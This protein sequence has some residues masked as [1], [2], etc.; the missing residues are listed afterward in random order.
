MLEVR[1][2]GTFEV[3][4]KNKLIDIPSRPAQSLFAY[5]ILNAGTSHRREKLAGLLW[6]DSMEETARD[7]LRHALWR[8][9]KALQSASAASYLQANDL[10][11]AFNASMEYW[12]DVVELAKLGENASAD[13]LITVLS[14]YHGELLPGFYDE[15]VGL[16]REHLHSIFEHHM[17]R[18]MSLLQEERRWLDILDW[19]ERWIK[20]GQKPE[21]AYRALMTVHAAK[22]D[23]SKVAATYQRCVKSLKELGVEPSEQ[24]H[25][26]Y[27]NLKASKENLET[28]SNISLREERTAPPKTNLPVPLTSFIGRE[29]EIEELKHLLSTTRLLTLTGAGGIGKTRLA[30]QLANDLVTAY[31]DGVW[32]V[33]LAPV[34][35]GRFVVQAVA[36]VLGVQESRVHSLTDS[37]NRFLREKQ[38]LI[39]LDNCE[40]VIESSA[41]LA[42]DLLSHCAHLQILT[43]S[44]ESLAITGETT[45]RVPVLTF[46]VL[47]HLPRLQNLSEFE[48]I[49]LFVERAVAVHPE[50]ALTPEN[51]FAVTQICHRLDG[52]PLA[53]ELAAARIKVFS[54]EEIA[55]RL[56]DRFSLLTHGSRTAL[57]RHQT[58][59]ALVEWSYD[60]LPESERILWRR[61]SVFIGGWTLEAA[62]SICSDAVLQKSHILELLSHLV[63]KSLVIVDPQNGSTRYQMLETIRQ[64]GQEI[65]ESSG[66]HSAI[67]RKHLVYFLELAETAE[68]NLLTIQQKMWFAKL[69]LEYGNMRAA[70]EWAMDAD[71]TN[72]LRLAA[73]LSQYWEVRGF[74]SEGRTA[75]ERALQPTPDVP[76]ELRAEGLRW[77]AK[78]AARQGDYARAKEPLK[79]SLELSRALGDKLGMAKSLHNLGMVFSLQGDYGA[80]KNS[81]ETGLALLKE[82]NDKRETA[83]LTTSLG[84]V[85]NYMGDYETARQYQEQSVTLF[86]ELGDKFGLFIALNNLGIV[87]ERQGDIS[88]ARR[89]YEASIATASELGEKNLVAY[90]LIGLAHVLYLQDD[91]TEAN[92]RYRESLHIAQE[93]GEKRCIAYCL[94]GLAQIALRVEHPSWA[95]QL[96]GAAASLRQ[97]IGA[98]LNQAEKDELDRD[99][100]VTRN[101]L[102]E[103]TFDSVYKAGSAM[104]LEQVIELVLKE[105][106]FE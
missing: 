42:T 66:E 75:L 70:F 95:A 36:Q 13:E 44:R 80:A 16:E 63:D 100:K 92:R 68:L 1:L 96:F 10:T 88:G 90:A 69:D 40:H 31:K 47:E 74:I 67:R 6:P 98:P 2:L 62:E 64:Y 103:R 93:I 23:M 15:W 77:Q 26:L 89:Y 97:A 54:L 27:K 87:L 49:Q 72:A 9:R 11:I 7:N 58:L 105:V 28:G 106:R 53:I 35:D 45:F 83:A 101:Q 29:R 22:G 18:L 71:I 21:P 37:L 38:A 17:A 102:G 32:W 34:K 33:E 86:R 19:G 30:I 51:A 91:L 56:N 48:S 39:I 14:E 12:L 76:N 3:K 82:T 85:V 50:L 4:H 25:S 79:E 59:R 41:Q 55:A 20:F 81:Y 60:L 24:T 52:I 57:P 99:V 5:L 78:F 43:T 94:E 104:T 73:A 46:P 65:V 84:N 61:L 8:L